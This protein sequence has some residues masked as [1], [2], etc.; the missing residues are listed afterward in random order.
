MNI[1]G[2]GRGYIYHRTRPTQQNRW[3]LWSLIGVTVV[4]VALIWQ[5]MVSLLAMVGSLG[6]VIAFWQKKPKYIRRLALVSSPAW[7]TYNAISGSYAGVVAEVLSVTSNL[8]GQYR[9]D[10]KHMPRRHSNEEPL[11]GT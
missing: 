6:N 11:S 1:L 10:L 8:F 9:F 7:L 2:A 4:A 5:G 3:I